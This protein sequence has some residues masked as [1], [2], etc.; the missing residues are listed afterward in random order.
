MNLKYSAPLELSTRKQL[1][2]QVNWQGGVLCITEY[3]S[4]YPTKEN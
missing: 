3:N 4:M 2:L 1:L